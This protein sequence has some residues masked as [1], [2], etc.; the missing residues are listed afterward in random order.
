[1]RTKPERFIQPLTLKNEYEKFP[2]IPDK[3]KTNS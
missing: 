1:M 2:L 3:S